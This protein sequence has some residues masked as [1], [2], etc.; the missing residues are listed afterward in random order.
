[1]IDFLIEDKIIDER[2]KLTVM[3]HVPE[4]EGAQFG[5]LSQEIQFGNAEP[6]K[7]EMWLHDKSVAIKTAMTLLRYAVSDEKDLKLVLERLLYI[8]Y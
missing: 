3:L 7:E 6:N 1:M 5:K 8:N 4:E 2:I